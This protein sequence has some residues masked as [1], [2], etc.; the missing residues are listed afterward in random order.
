MCGRYALYGPSS[1]LREQFDAE[2]EHFEFAPR[3]NAAP[4]QWLPVLRQRAGG[5]R[6]IHQLRWGLLPAWAKDEAIA[7]RLIN[8]RAESVA[9]KPAFRAAWRRRRCIVP[10]NGFYEWKAVAGGKQPYYI[11]AANDALFALAGL[12]ERWT[13]PEDG[14]R[15]D[16][17]TIVTTE[18]EA[19]MRALHQ[20]MPVILPAQ[21]CAR[22]LDR[23]ASEAD[24]RAL[25]TAEPPAL[26][27]HPVSKAVGKV[28]NEGETLIRPLP[29]EST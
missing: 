3:Y 11:H 22:W 6:V 16:T 4:M 14:E 1:R 8:A 7:T 23:A 18:A 29:P 21:A 9:D 27:M 19:P 15:V 25:L 17:F 2:I 12:W 26:A 28:S 13:R 5:E 10:A 20:R 24:L